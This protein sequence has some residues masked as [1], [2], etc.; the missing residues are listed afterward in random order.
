M[1]SKSIATLGVF[2]LILEILVV[3]LETIIYRHI[4]YTHDVCPYFLAY[5]LTFWESNEIELLSTLCKKLLRLLC[6]MGVTEKN[7][8]NKI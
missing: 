4:M 7:T 2:K 6:A 1:I 8:S 3:V 5:I